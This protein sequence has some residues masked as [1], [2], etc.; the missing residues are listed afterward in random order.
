MP[1]RR[2]HGIFPL[3]IYNPASIRDAQRRSQIQLPFHTKGS[4]TSNNDQILESISQV[5]HA[6]I[7][8]QPNF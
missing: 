8:D 5:L 4:K 2:Q 3:D 1:I 7:K 6:E